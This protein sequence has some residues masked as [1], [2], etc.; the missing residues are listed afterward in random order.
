[1]KFRLIDR[2]LE[3][4]T[5]RVVAIKNVSSAEEYLGD[6][7]PG[8]PVLPGVFMIEAMI[9]A[10]REVLNLRGKPRFVLGQVRALKYGSFVRPGET[11][12]VEVTLE[13][14]LP[15]GSVQFKGQGTVLRPGGSSAE[16]ATPSDTA[17]AGRFTMRALT[18]D[19]ASASPE[20]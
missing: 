14:E 8:F 7:F 17:V 20:T 1:M 11:L 16:G 19:Q 12:R 9:Q 4:S 13:K 10:A 2:V 5:T 3:V 18:P 6:H 15:D